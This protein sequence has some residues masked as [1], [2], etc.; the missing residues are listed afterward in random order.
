M[1]NNHSKNGTILYTCH[2]GAPAAVRTGRFDHV[3]RD[4]G[5]AGIQTPDALIREALH[6]RLAEG[7]ETGDGPL[8]RR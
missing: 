3:E 8:S 6:R 1:Q 2:G 7:E 4:H 5:R